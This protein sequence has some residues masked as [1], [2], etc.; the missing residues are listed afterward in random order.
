MSF[1]PTGTRAVGE[2]SG[3]P[4]GRPLSPPNRTTVFEPALYVM[5]ASHLPGGLVDGWSCVQLAPPHSQ[6]SRY[7]EPEDP[8]PWPR[9]GLLVPPNRLTPPCPSGPMLAA[10]R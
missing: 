3:A 2:G 8:R 7:A 4:V 6:R 5:L 1:C 9:Y 10:A